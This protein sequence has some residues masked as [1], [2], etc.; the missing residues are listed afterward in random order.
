MGFDIE[1]NFT[2]EDQEATFGSGVE[3]SNMGEGATIG[4]RAVSNRL[5]S[6]DRFQAYNIEIPSIN[7]SE[8]T[9]NMKFPIYLLLSSVTLGAIPS[10]QI[11]FGKIGD[12]SVEANILRN[13]VYNPFFILNDSISQDLSVYRRPSDSRLEQSVDDNVFDLSELSS[14]NPFKNTTLGE[15]NQIVDSQ[16]K[17]LSRS[18]SNEDNRSDFVQDF[19]KDANVSPEDYKKLKIRKASST[20]L[21]GMNRKRSTSV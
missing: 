7:Y 3:L 4:A 13:R 5:H 10:N 19:K 8:T 11:L 20:E 9:T 18:I 1:G 2:K 6:I 15:F 17:S 16:I 12:D 14:V 21:R